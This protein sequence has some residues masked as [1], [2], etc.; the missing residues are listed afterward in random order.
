MKILFE[1][2]HPKHFHLFRN[3]ISELSKRHHQIAIT[4]R[5]KDVTTN[6]LWASGFP[7]TVLTR[8]NSSMGN[9]SLALELLLRDWRLYRFAKIFSPDV[10]VARVG[11]SAA[12]VGFLL[13]KPVIVFEDTEDGNLQ[14]KISFPFVDKICTAMHYEKNWGKK[15][16]RYP[17]FDELAY[18]HPKRFTPNKM[19]PLSYDLEPGSYIIVRFV[20]WQAAH[21]VGQKGISIERRI[22]IVK[23]LEKFGRVL[24]TSEAAL[25]P[26]FEEYKIPALPEHFHHLLAFAK[27]TF[28]ESST[29]ATEG[30]ML[31]V[32]GILVN[33]MNWG[34]VNRLV[35][36][37]G[38]LF[39]TDSVSEA[40]K[41][42]EG[43][44]NNPLVP[45]EWVV[46]R[47][48]LL[49]NEID[50]IEWIVNEIESNE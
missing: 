40:L 26:E 27:L 15:H 20:S 21:D 2:T 49:R 1:I 32:P 46:K 12:H 43:L 37:Y 6:L 48:N 35:R 17:S 5:E 30:A 16:V 36:H 25:P 18:L 47:E 14:Q 42:A 38:M 13:K 3:A 44:L 24:I 22:H 41:M 28:G 10:I 39:Q 19:V 29:V 34:S 9:F 33:T 8:Q 7:F 31:G 11:P 50:L 45:R 4:V 23:L